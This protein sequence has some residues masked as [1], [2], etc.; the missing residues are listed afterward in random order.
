MIDLYWKF[1]GWAEQPLMITNWAAL[2]FYSLVLSL[3]YGVMREVRQLRVHLAKVL[4]ILFE[5]RKR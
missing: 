3:L 5:E 2:V 4:D 1:A